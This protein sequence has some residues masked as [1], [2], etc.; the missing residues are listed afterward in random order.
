MSDV[1]DDGSALL[2]RKHQGETTLA[3]N[4]TG[5]GKCKSCVCGY[6]DDVAKCGKELVTSAKKCGEKVVS[7][8]WEVIK[9]VAKCATGKCKVKKCK[10]KALQC[11]APKSCFKAIPFMDCLDNL[12]KDKGGDVKAAINVLKSTGETGYKGMKNVVLKG[13]PS[14]SKQLGKG[15]ADLMPKEVEK[16][17]TKQGWDNLLD[18]FL[19]AAQ[20]MAYTVYD[21]LTTVG[22]VLDSFLDKVANGPITLPRNAED[23]GWCVFKWDFTM[24]WFTDC[25]YFGA[26]D[27]LWGHVAQAYNPKMWD[28]FDDDYKKMGKALAHCATLTTKIDIDK[29]QSIQIATP[30]MSLQKMDF[31][32][33]KTVVSGVE[34]I[35]NAL[36]LAYKA[37]G[38]ALDPIQKALDDLADYVKRLI[39]D[40]SLLFQET[41]SL[42]QTD[43]KEGGLQGLRRSFM[44]SKK[45]NMDNY[46]FMARL[47]FQVGVKFK[48]FKFA[49]LKAARA[50]GIGLYFGCL[51]AQFKVMAFMNVRILSVGVSLPPGGIDSVGDLTWAG[52]FQL[53]YYPKA[54]PSYTNNMKF[55]GVFQ[56]TAGLKIA[57]FKGTGRTSVSFWSP[58]VTGKDVSNYKLE[59]LEKPSGYGFTIAVS[60]PKKP[61]GSGSGDSGSTDLRQGEVGPDL[62]TN[63]RGQLHAEGIT[64]HDLVT[65]LHQLSTAENMSGVVPTGSFDARLQLYVCFDSAARCNHDGV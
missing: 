38:K 55:E 31:C 30:F 6:E 10:K 37:A 15:L 41:F 19:G 59:K 20:D 61:G 60:P 42:L 14:V 51:K 32:L 36:V 64:E 27:T 50:I 43:S 65:G 11:E 34:V 57:N 49:G 58:E 44:C 1:V 4:A 12:A 63:L 18:S 35:A 46:A 39:S 16:M 28:K 17:F 24:F 54:Y 5:K 13:I 33:P 52:D 48:H 21:G 22:D 23:G 26:V 62:A 2:Q 29:G 56:V 47:Q 7:C 53:K 3:T 8:T 40:N 9:D 45:K 25:G